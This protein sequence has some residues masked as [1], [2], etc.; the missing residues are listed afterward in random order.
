MFSARVRAT[1]IDKVT[2][3][4]YVWPDGAKATAI[5]QEVIQ[6]MGE[7]WSEI[8]L[9]LDVPEGLDRVGVNVYAERSADGR[10][11]LADACVGPLR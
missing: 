4:A 10:L 1:G 9:R 3:V 2:V 8:I 5:A 6:P 11:W 7:G